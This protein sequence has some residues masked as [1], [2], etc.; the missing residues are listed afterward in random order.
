M[1]DSC[2]QNLSGER[3]IKNQFAKTTATKI[4]VEFPS[5]ESEKQDRKRNDKIK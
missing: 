5:N 1:S 3:E 2:L 4:A